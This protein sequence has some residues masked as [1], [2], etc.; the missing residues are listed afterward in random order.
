VLKLI[1][2][3][4]NP[5]FDIDIIFMANYSFMVGDVPSTMSRLCDFVNHKINRG[6]LL[7]VTAFKKVSA[8]HCMLVCW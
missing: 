5:R 7:T 3:S 2:L 8:A 1:H 6:S 4:S